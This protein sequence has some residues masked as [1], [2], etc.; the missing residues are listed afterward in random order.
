MT[1]LIAKFI[2]RKNASFIFSLYQPAGCHPMSRWHDNIL[3]SKAINSAIKSVKYKDSY[4]MPIRS[5]TPD[6]I[7]FDKPTVIVRNLVPSIVEDN[8][9]CKN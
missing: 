4:H 3:L 9:I 8:A 5:I 1:D 2:I 7:L 6:I